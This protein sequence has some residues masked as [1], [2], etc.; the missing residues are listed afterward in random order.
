MSKNYAILR[1]AKLNSPK[2]L[3]NCYVHNDRII[4]IE[5][6]N[7]SRTQNNVNII[8]NNGK[9]YES[10]MQDE[11]IRLKIEGVPERTIRKD[12]ILGMEVYLGFSSDA[13][14]TFDLDKWAEANLE[15]L[16]KTFNP[17][18]HEIH[19][20]NSRTGDQ[21]IKK[22]QN[23]KHM[24]MHMDESCPH[25]HAF[26]VPIDEKGNLNSSYYNR[27][28]DAAIERQTDYAEHMAQFKLERGERFTNAH[29]TDINEYYQNIKIAV[30]SELPPVEKDEPAQDYRDRANIVYQ[31]ALSNHR[32]EIVKKNQEIKQVK[33]E[34]K[35][36]V[37]EA[38]EKGREAE[39]VCAVINQSLEGD[40]VVDFDVARELGN[41]RKEQKAFK[42]AIEE[43]PQ[44]ERAAMALELYEELMNWQLMQEMDR[45]LEERRNS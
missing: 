8:D 3:R 1:V 45:E 6:V 18:N 20:T 35:I 23:I 16:D 32:N 36:A 28:R 10:M 2:K 15:W 5:N 7:P 43:Y 30:Q 40:E 21:E 14:G 27:G 4:H 13:M 37:Y 44:R 33:S 39:E 26:V 11:L 41:A 17:P 34:A 24:V 29:H 38:N 25:I 9:T 12:A 31:I 42:K 22:V 19:Y